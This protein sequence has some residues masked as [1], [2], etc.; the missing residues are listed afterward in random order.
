MH[1]GVTTNDTRVREQ[2]ISEQDISERD[3]SERDIATYSTARRKAMCKLLKG[4]L[5]TVGR[6]ATGTVR[7]MAMRV[8][9]EWCLRL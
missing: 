6:K 5:C 1:S 7:K 4:C 8:V 9:Q 3:I 2:D